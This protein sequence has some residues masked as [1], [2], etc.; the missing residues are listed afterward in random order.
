MNM[1]CYP[2]NGENLTEMETYTNITPNIFWT[3]A[4]E[5]E[6]IFEK[7]SLRVVNIDFMN[8]KVLERQISHESIYT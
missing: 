1:R 3:L 2:N 6:I 7:N 8:S 5:R 4:R